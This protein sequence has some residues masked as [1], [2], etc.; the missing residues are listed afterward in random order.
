MAE[1]MLVVPPGWNEV[2]YLMMEDKDVHPATKAT[3]KRK[4]EKVARGRRKRWKE[5]YIRMTPCPQCHG[6]HGIERISILKIG[7]KLNRKK[8]IGRRQINGKGF[9]RWCFM[10][11][12]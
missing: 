4:I 9:H 5:D 7:M 8:M 2:P 3:V 10:A 12:A 6:E 1:E 11:N